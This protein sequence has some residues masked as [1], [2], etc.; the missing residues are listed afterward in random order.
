MRKIG[1]YLGCILPF[2]LGILLQ[3]VVI[4]TGSLVYGMVKGFQLASTGVTDPLEIADT[5]TNGLTAEI[6]LGITA[7]YAVAAIVIFGIWY[8]KLHK[9]SEKP[10]LKQ[11]L[12]PKNIL[13]I[14]LLGISLQIGISFLLNL[15]AA[16]KPEWFE[17][18]IELIE[19]LGMGNSLI[20]VL[21]V[22]IIA[23]ISEEIIFR[24]VIL[25]KAKKIMPLLAANILQAVLFG[26]YHM[27]LIQ[28]TY[29]FLIGLLFGYLCIKLKSLYGGILLHMAVNLG[30]ILLNLLPE[31]TE[32]PNLVAAIIV[33]AS[34][35]GIVLVT[36]YFR[37]FKIQ[38]NEEGTFSSTDY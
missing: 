19:T 13:M 11:A 20:S 23:P 8:K 29:A 15:I 25:T 14:A 34:L 30:G 35:A 7:C 22:G 31:G 27:N 38:S 10:D 3:L 36:L 12:T 2:I 37:E 21:Y 17:S 26:I 5:I 28:G 16:M 4:F 18:Y 33:I 1:S 32:M 6:L 9:D 24:G